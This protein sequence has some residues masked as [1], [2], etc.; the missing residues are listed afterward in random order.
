[1]HTS[2]LKSML[3]NLKFTLEN[4]KSVLEN[5]KSEL[6]NCTVELCCF[7][8][9]MNITKQTDSAAVADML[10]TLST[11]IRSDLASLKRG[12]DQLFQKQDQ[13]LCTLSGETPHQ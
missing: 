13:S 4:L 12:Q 11:E 9:K 8:M 2:T 3:G 10:S 1:M 7:K 6:N 5:L